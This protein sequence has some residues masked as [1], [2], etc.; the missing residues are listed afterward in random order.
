[1]LHLDQSGRANVGR[2]LRTLLRRD[3]EQQYVSAQRSIGFQVSTILIILQDLAADELEESF[4]CIDEVVKD[5]GVSSV[6]V[7]E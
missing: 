2:V 6:L 3:S 4:D 7:D 5:N 1:L